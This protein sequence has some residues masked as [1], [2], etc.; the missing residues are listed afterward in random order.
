MKAI[1][2]K[3]IGKIVLLTFKWW[4]WNHNNFL[5]SSRDMCKISSDQDSWESNY[6]IC[7]FHNFQLWVK[8]LSEIMTWFHFNSHNTK[9]V[10]T[11]IFCPPYIICITHLYL[12]IDDTTFYIIASWVSWFNTPPP[13]P[14]PTPNPPNP[15]LS[16]IQPSVS[17]ATQTLGLPTATAI[18]CLKKF[19]KRL[20]LS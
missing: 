16:V 6:N 14:S 19:S 18:F 3:F 15:H 13:P 9:Y 1:L 7:I 10:Y 17:L 20:L 2:H 4:W 11:R 8:T 5:H 12:Y